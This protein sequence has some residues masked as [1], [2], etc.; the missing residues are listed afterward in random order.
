VEVVM[1]RL[2]WIAVAITLAYSSAVVAADGAPSNPNILQGIQQ[3]Q[4]S[5]AQEAATLQAIQTALQGLAPP[6]VS[7]VAVTP[8]FETNGNASMT[9]NYVN[10]LAGVIVL[11]ELVAQN[12]T[13]E[14]NES[15]AIGLN[16]VG[17]LRALTTSSIVYCRFTVSNGTK[18]D[19]VASGV[20]RA[21][22]GQI[23]A[24]DAK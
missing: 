20:L 17:V 18:A 11:V 16:S 3:L 21:A 9:C 23:Y 22:T 24:Q 13:V 10:R 19:I 4:L 12:G 15:S 6:P 8:A 5:A 1:R 2:S 14:A 7:N